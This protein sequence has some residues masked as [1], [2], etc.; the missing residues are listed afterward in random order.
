[1]YVAQN[2]QMR[3]CVHA[4]LCGTA[5]E[6]K[7]HFI[8]VCQS[9]NQVRH[10]YVYPHVGVATEP[11]FRNVTEMLFPE[12]CVNLAKS[13]M[14]AKKVKKGCTRKLILCDIEKRF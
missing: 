4:P 10:G 11:T 6:N 1:M 12:K 7:I 2:A 3:V 14:E 8:F 5:E 13:V 9:Q